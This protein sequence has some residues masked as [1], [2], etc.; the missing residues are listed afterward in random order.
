L[1]G[2]NISTKIKIYRYFTVISSRTIPTRGQV[3]I[4]RDD[5][6]IAW[7]IRMKRSGT[8]LLASM[9]FIVLSLVCCG[10]NN[11]NH[12][13]SGNKLINS[14]IGNGNQAANPRPQAQNPQYVADEVLVKFTP[15]TRSDAIN[16][17]QAQLRLETVRKFRSPNLFL[18]KITDGTAVEAIIQKLKT[19][20]AVEYAEPNYVVKANPQD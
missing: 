14:D 20:S 3:V 19:Y 2:R 4:K 15:D 17:I 1:I 13:K 9:V 5:M 7:R 12:L 16:R 8:S 6:T 10:Q 18:M 11:N